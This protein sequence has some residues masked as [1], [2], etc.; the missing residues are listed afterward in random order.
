MGER[1]VYLVADSEHAVD[2]AARFFERFDHIQIAGW[3]SGSA[4][5]EWRQTHGVAGTIEHITADT[6]AVRL[7]AWKTIVADIRDPAAF[8]KA[9][10]PESILIPLQN[11]AAA[12]DGLPPQTSLSLVC[13]EGKHCT[14]AASLLWNSGYRRLAI[15]RGGFAA[16]VEHG[17]PLKESR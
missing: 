5:E 8:R 10:I 3:F 14:F 17:L 7:A 4:V 2:R 6:L 12:L 13:D 9:H 1:S 11:L 15:L 16:Y